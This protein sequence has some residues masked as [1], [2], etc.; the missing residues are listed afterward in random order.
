MDACP[1]RLAC[2]QNTTVFL[3]NSDCSVKP[4]T[5][6]ILLRWHLDKIT[7]TY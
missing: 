1:E 2:P 5:L 6:L 3:E 7:F 4:G